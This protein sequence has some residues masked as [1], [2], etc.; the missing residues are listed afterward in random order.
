MLNNKKII[1]VYNNKFYL[2]NYKF[3]EKMNMWPIDEIN[4]IKYF[5]TNELLFESKSNEKIISLKNE[6][7][8]ITKIE[9]NIFIGMDS[10]ISNEK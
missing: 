7:Y 10:S 1:Y 8:A 2:N 4:N 9:E 6:Y 5:Y 3:Y